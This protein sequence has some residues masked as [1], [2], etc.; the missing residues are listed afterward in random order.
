MSAS[1][2]RCSPPPAH[3][4]LTAAITGFHTPQCHDEIFSSASRVRRECSRI[5]SLSRG[6]LDDVHPRAERLAV[7]GV[8]DH[9]YVGVG[10]EVGP[11]GLELVEHQR[12]EGV[13]GVRPVQDQPA[14]AVRL[15]DDEPFVGAHDRGISFHGLPFH[16]SG[17]LGRPSTRSPRMFLLMSVV[18]PS[19]PLA[20]LRIMPWT[21][22][23]SASG[24]SVAG[25]ATARGAQQVDH[26]VLDL[27]VEGG[28]VY[29]ADRRRG[30]R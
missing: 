7:G 11:R 2:T 20:R 9:P 1:A 5:A 23:G 14:D 17:S 13:A 21:S 30:A 28:L 12:I 6:D 24:S 8:D 27:L 15:L 10:V 4:P 22:R 25:Q 26:Q 16:G 19:V 18:P 29:L 3:T